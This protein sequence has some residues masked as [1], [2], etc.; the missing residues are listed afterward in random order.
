MCVAIEMGFSQETLSALPLCLEAIALYRSCRFE[1]D[2]REG[3][4]GDSVNAVLMEIDLKDV[5]TI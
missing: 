2:G 3:E 1:H 5:R 4:A